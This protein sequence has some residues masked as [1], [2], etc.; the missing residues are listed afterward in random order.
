MNIKDKPKQIFSN[1]QLYQIAHAAQ[2]VKD[3]CM[4]EIGLSSLSGDRYIGQSEGTL[5][6][7]IRH[8][9]NV[10]PINMILEVISNE[11]KQDV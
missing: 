2:N 5:L 4:F 7:H 1:E 10:L 8:L 6:P 11:G 3:T 9:I